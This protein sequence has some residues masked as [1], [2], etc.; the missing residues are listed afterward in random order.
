MATAVAA[1]LGQCLRVE[2]RSQKGRNLSLLAVE[3]TVKRT[4]LRRHSRRNTP[5]F[6]PLSGVGFF[7]LPHPDAL[8]A[9]TPFP[10][11]HCGGSGGIG[12]AA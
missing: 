11:S 5:S 2:V 4:L 12:R 1:L 9:L 6:S 10:R 3:G 7:G 8:E